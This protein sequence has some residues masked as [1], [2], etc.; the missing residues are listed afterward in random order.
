MNHD[1]DGDGDDDGG[2]S[3]NKVMNLSVFKI[4]DALTLGGEASFVIYCFP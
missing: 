2:D 3:L 4:W 1:E